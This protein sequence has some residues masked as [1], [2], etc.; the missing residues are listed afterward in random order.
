VVASH[1]LRPEHGEQGQEPVVDLARAPLE[2]RDRRWRR[3]RLHLFAAEC[4]FNLLPQPLGR[5]PR[6]RL[7]AF[8]RHTIEQQGGQSQPRRLRPAQLSQASNAG[9]GR[10]RAEA[11]FHLASAREPQQIAQERERRL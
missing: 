6:R 8:H 5:N 10:E 3:L 7:P 2:G 11:A 1:R 4:G 9:Q